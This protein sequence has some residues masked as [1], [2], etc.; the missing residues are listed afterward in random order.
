MPPFLVADAW[1]R[2]KSTGPVASPSLR[3]SLASPGA[4]LP[5]TRD[6]RYEDR[7]VAHPPA[8]RGCADPGAPQMFVWG[9]QNQRSVGID[10]G[11]RSARASTL[12]R[13]INRSLA[14]R[15]GTIEGPASIGRLT[16]RL[17]CK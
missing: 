12:R 10:K 8:G 11:T 17:R 1:T 13:L 14:G 15:D 2:A 9:L 7:P 4:D 16:R 6:I 3:G 5:G